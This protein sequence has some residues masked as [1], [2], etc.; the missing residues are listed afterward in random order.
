M[1]SEGSA[2]NESLELLKEEQG[3]AV[4]NACGILVGTVGRKG[5]IGSFDGSS[6]KHRKGLRDLFLF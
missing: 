2:R 4:S 3:Q 1:R 5:L 6:V